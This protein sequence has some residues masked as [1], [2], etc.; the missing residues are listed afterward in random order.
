MEKNC[1]RECTNLLKK[2]GGEIKQIIH[3]DNVFGDNLFLIQHPKGYYIQHY[4]IQKGNRII[5][6]FLIEKG[7]IPLEK[8]IFLYKNPE[9]LRIV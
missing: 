1:Y 5:D 2:I 4:V 8:Y 6:P 7:E 3:K 9:E